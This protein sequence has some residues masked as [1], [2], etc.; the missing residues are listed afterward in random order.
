MKSG[1]KGI[2]QGAWADFHKVATIAA[3]K[4]GLKDDT[5]TD[6]IEFQL[7]VALI[8]AMK[9][10]KRT[11]SECDSKHVRVIWAPTAAPSS[12]SYLCSDE[13]ECLQVGQ[14]DFYRL[15]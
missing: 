11:D 4:R 14:E 6:F 3:M 5:S 13:K 10:I 8:A 15:P 9:R 1:L 12:R 7:E 2:T